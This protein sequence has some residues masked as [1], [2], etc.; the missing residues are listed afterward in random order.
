MLVVELCL[1]ESKVMEVP[2]DMV[3]EDR[4]ILVEDFARRRTDIL[5]H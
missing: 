5:Q 3:D 4:H 1:L 2:S